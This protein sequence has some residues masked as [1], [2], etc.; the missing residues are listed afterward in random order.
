MSTFPWKVMAI[1]PSGNLTILPHFVPNMLLMIGSD[2]PTA[3]T[4][5]RLL[6]RHP[7]PPLLT[8]LKHFASNPSTAPS[9]IMDE[10][11]TLAF[12]SP[13]TK[14]PPNKLPQLLIY[15]MKRL[16]GYANGLPTHLSKCRHLLPCQWHDSK[17]HHQWCRLPPRPTES[18]K[19]SCSPLPT[20]LDHQWPCQWCPPHTLQD[21][22]KWRLFSCR[23]Q[24][25][26]NLYWK[27]TC[28]PHPC[29]FRRSRPPTA[30]YWFSC[31]YWQQHRSRHPPKWDKNLPSL[32]A[33]ATGGSRTKS[34][35]VNSTFSGSLE[36]ST[37]LTTSPSTTPTLPAWHHHRR[38]DTNIYKR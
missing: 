16:F 13:S 35:R 18:Q 1:Q 19:Q 26:R 27:P 8:K 15:W 14:A 24:N 38:C 37:W 28:L 10:V 20:R 21:H 12:S 4:S 36:N 7:Q 11:S 5:P 33:C 23:V 31:Q 29:S 3:H 2:L 22:K 6:S 17:D 34:N 25:R 32:L 30:T 9:C